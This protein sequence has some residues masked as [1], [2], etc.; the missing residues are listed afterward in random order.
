LSDVVLI[1]CCGKEDHKRRAVASSFS[2][3]V[4]VLL[5]AVAV[6]Q[7]E[8]TSNVDNATDA[9][10]QA[11]IRA[12]FADCTVLTIAHRLH[13]IIDSDRILVLQAGQLAEMDA[14]TALLQ[15]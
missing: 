13:T 10:I 8:A 11:T 7:D 5:T 2:I 4:A 12:A 3:S 15:V 6:Q 1:V 14:P 9:L